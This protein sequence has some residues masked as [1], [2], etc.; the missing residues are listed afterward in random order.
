MEVFT[1][2]LIWTQMEKNSRSE[3]KKRSAANLAK[4]LRLEKINEKEC[5]V[6][7]QSQKTEFN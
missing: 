1:I 3:L 7:S 2:Q 5:Q 6:F 4:K